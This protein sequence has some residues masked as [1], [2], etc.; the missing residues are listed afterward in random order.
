[1]LIKS[2]NIKK[3][4]AVENVKFDF[5]NSINAFSGE[6][7]IGKTTIID[8]ILWILS[9]ET[10]ITG[11]DNTKNLD[12]ND[13]TKPIEVEMVVVL[14]NGMELELKREYQPKFT[15]E[16]IF[17]SYSNKFWINDANYTST[18]YFNRLKKEFGITDPNVKKF[19]VIRALIDFDYFGTLDYQVAREV[20]EKILKFETS[21]DI[22]NQE[23][24]MSIKNDLIGQNFDIAKTKTM[25]NSQI[26][27]KENEIQKAKDQIKILKD[28]RKPLDK[29]ELENLKN[30]VENLKNGNYEH[31]VEYK[32]AIDEIET[33]DKKLQTTN[34]EL[35]KLKD[36]YNTLDYKN[37]NILKP[38]KDKKE[39]VLR[40]REDFVRIKNGIRKC[41]NCN[42]ELNKDEI[43]KELQEISSRGKKLN[44]EIQ[45]LESQIKTNEINE[46]TLVINDKQAEYDK[47]FNETQERKKSFNALL[48]K[49]DFEQSNFYR[50]RQ[51]KIDELNEQINKMTSE[52]NESTLNELEKQQSIHEEDYAKLLVKK[53]LLIDFEKDKINEINDKVKNVFPSVE[54]VLIEVSDRGAEKK[55]CK[56]QFNGVDYLRLNDGQ[57]IKT[58]FEIIDGLSQAFG[59]ESKLPIVFDKLRDLSKPNIMDL[60]EKAQTQIFTTFVGN[61]SEIKLYQM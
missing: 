32:S 1:M 50:V 44:L 45:E 57:R 17:S 40:L 20:I 46:L 56:P 47:L 8:S 23:K 5:T 35:K 2:L 52:S 30:S 58:G 19:N 9:D 36:E 59:V 12:D 11:L 3:F 15:K 16:G 27:I 33:L 29:K 48:E 49:E 39:D 53:E 61:E 34:Q 13:N 41:P 24:Y 28:T 37:N 60:K 54:F 25:Y 10:L 18:E 38:L 31:S 55:T 42:Y 21:S 6:N 4:R 51:E 22:I 43:V 7:G 26:S 14:G